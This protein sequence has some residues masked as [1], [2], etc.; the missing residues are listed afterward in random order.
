MS[1]H[2]EGTLKRRIKDFPKDDDYVCNYERM[3]T[4][5]KGDQQKLRR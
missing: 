2:N 4:G 3:F 1:L 5:E